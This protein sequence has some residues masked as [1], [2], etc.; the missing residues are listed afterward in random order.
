ML[1]VFTEPTEDLES[2]LREFAFSRNKKMMLRFIVTK[3][4]QNYLVIQNLL[5]LDKH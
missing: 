5:I 2:A 4:L 1:K 3:Y